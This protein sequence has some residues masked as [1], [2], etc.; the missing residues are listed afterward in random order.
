MNPLLN[1][2]I[3]I[4]GGW[5]D[6]CV[7]WLLNWLVVSGV[8]TESNGTRTQRIITTHTCLQITD[9][10]FK[11]QLL[12]HQ[13]LWQITQILIW[14]FLTGYFFLPN[15]EGRLEPFTIPNPQPHVF[16][17]ETTALCYMYNILNNLLKTRTHTKLNAW[18]T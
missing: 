16:F 4:I 12:G 7:M 10:N 18:F 6:C 9:V 13:R 8:V 5:R 2:I 11:S 3:I 14:L 15:L 17:F 1:L